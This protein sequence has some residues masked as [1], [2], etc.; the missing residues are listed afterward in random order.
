MA[1]I[2]LYEAGMRN[3]DGKYVKFIQSRNQIEVDDY[4]DIMLTTKPEGFDV[5]KLEKVFRCVSTI[6]QII[7]DKYE[8]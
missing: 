6:P 4:I 8:K 1:D 3:S 5:V 7:S 2:I